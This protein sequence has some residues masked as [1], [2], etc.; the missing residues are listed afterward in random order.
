MLKF[1]FLAVLLTLRMTRVKSEK[2]PKCPNSF[3][4]DLNVF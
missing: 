3:V 2:C 4:Q 1:V